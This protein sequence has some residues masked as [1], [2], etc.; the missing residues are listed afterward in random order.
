MKRKISVL[1]LVV[2]MM[3]C[4]TAFFTVNV[5]ADVKASS[6]AFDN[7]L[8]G[9]D[10]LDTEVEKINFDDLYY[11]SCR[12]FNSE[13]SAESM[14]GGFIRTGRNE[15]SFEISY[16]VT[17]LEAPTA[18]SVFGLGFKN[19]V[20]ESVGNEKTNLIK[21]GGYEI[22]F[23]KNQR[24]DGVAAT[25]LS[26]VSVIKNGALSNTTSSVEKYATASLP[27][28][29]DFSLNSEYNFKLGAVLI[30][31]ETGDNLKGYY[32]Y[33]DVTQETNTQRLFGI[34]DYFDIRQAY[35]DKL[36]DGFATGV[37]SGDGEYQI[38]TKNTDNVTTLEEV[39]SYD[40][41]HLDQGS[42]PNYSYENAS[43]AMFGCASVLKDLSME[44][45]MR[46]IIETP[47][48]GWNAFEIGLRNCQGSLG[49]KYVYGNGGYC[50]SI[51]NCSMDPD[52]VMVGANSTYSLSI[53]RN[54]LYTNSKWY[55]NAARV[56]RM[57][58]WFNTILRTQGASY[59]LTVGLRRIMDGEEAVGYYAYMKAN[60]Q[61]IV[62]F[63][64]Y[65]DWEANIDYFGDVLTGC[66][67]NQ[68]SYIITTRGNV[69]K[70]FEQVEKFDLSNLVPVT[71][72]GITYQAKTKASATENVIGRYVYGKDSIGVSYKFKYTGTPV[73]DLSLKGLDDS[74]NA[75]A[76]RYA[77]DT[78][79][80]TFRIY[81]MA[82]KVAS[83]DSGALD[84]AQ[85]GIT[86]EE[87]EEY[88]IEYGVIRYRYKGGT[89]YN[90][91]QVF[92]KINDVDVYTYNVDYIVSSTLGYYV[93]GRV[94]G[95]QGSVT[96]IPREENTVTVALTATTA[97][98][99]CLVNGRNAVYYESTAPM[100]VI[101]VEY[102]I[103]SGEDCIS[104]N[105][106]GVVTGLKEGT[107]VVKVKV[108]SQYGE[109]F[110]NEVTLQINPI[111]TSFQ[112]LTYSDNS[113]L[114]IGL[115]VGGGAIIIGGLVVLFIM[116][117]KKAKK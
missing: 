7:A 97:K 44:I 68:G 53:K 62:D 74:T 107:A 94:T 113:G 71:A 112:K 10:V 103:V 96:I 80:N 37:V 14:F 13:N 59:E 46:V 84:L 9:T 82:T 111:E 65:F 76:V 101:D 67:N 51:G 1:S 41:L 17:V 92:L 49:G 8:I 73:L 88:I 16:D 86:L 38:T 21:S 15:T 32:I 114:W 95:T 58:D 70:E 102:V 6:T 105:P 99:S 54:G 24:L 108:T 35:A 18:D 61:I 26:T 117:K 3:L 40:I 87:G 83:F 20:N 29:L 4:F 69:D 104:I 25:S 91:A 60:D 11:S 116:L 90:R 30:T 64:D 77:L 48:T 85:K 12:V 75:D 93:G 45:S 55:I 79:N 100:G 115:S 28:W 39:K 72:E 109:Y 27:S 50:F 63:Y 110:S 34:Y 98:E 33:L 5:Y 78:K 56:V 47:A 89:E 23:G 43:S 19:V 66:V 57:P 42:S 31:D 2:A 81:T 106:Y 52:G 22:L 36:I